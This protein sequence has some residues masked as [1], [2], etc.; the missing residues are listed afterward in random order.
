MA[1]CMR[2]WLGMKWRRRISH[3]Y[4]S[5]KEN[6]RARFGGE[7]YDEE[8]EGGCRRTIAVAYDRAAR[9]ACFGLSGKLRHQGK[10]HASLWG[11]SLL[12]GRPRGTCA[13]V[14][15]ERGDGCTDG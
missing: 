5:T 8:G 15:I 4:V 9:T 12:Q 3:L 6:R 2:I 10:T 7:D 1:W 11:K 13:E 14:S